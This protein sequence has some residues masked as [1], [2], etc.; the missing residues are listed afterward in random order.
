MTAALIQMLLPTAIAN[1]N[2]TAALAETRRELADTFNGVTA[3]LRSPAKGLWT[4]PDGRVE[5]DDVVIVEV[6]TPA[7]D[8]QWWRSYAAKL[9]QRFGQETIHIRAVPVDL[10]DDAP[11]T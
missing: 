8:R 7:F 4:A 10:L 3:Y 2:A 11:R 9:A 5:A 6:V 1:G